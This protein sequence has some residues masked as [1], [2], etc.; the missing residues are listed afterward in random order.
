MFFQTILSTSLC[1]FE[2]THGDEQNTALCY[3]YGYGC[4]VLA[5]THPGGKCICNFLDCPGNL[6]GFDVL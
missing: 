4:I 1:F 5:F 2:H 6:I 3:L